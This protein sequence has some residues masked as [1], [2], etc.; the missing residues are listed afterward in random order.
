MFN[1]VL[2][3]VVPCYNEQE[4]LNETNKRILTKLYSLMDE[5]KISPLSRIVYVDDGSKDDTWKLI[6]KYHEQD[7]TVSGLKIS[8]NR[9]HQNAVFAGLMMSKKLCDCVISVDAD[10]QDDI[11]VFDKFIDKFHDGCDV[12]Y[13]VRN[14]RETD[15]FFKRKTATLFY[16]VLQKMGAEVV[17]NHADYRLMSRRAVEALST[18]PEVN[19]YLRG[20]V[21]LIGFKSDTVEYK[22]NERF[23]GESKYPLSKMLAL[24]FD[25]ITSFS[26]KPMRIITVLGALV[27]FGGIFALIY[28][29]VVHNMG[30]TEA[31]WTSLISSIWL[32]G[33]IQILCIGII[34]EYIGKIFTEVKARPR[35]VVDKF[36]NDG[37]AI[38]DFSEIE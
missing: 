10:L 29:L 2:Y 30:R 3:V 14:D 32:I 20:M 5:K 24:A 38:D 37:E 4:V 35:F 28:S 36:L 12:V 16:T 18:F 23:A 21:P 9:G 31:G 22:R 27:C 17:Y 15:T 8:R 13:G 25:G 19:L 6:E 11:D 33:G 1:T 26:V 34:G 7:S